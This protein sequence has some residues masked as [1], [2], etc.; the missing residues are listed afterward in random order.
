MSS[1]SQTRLLNGETHHHTGSNETL[2]VWDKQLQKVKENPDFHG[3]NLLADKQTK[4]T[5]W[6][7][8]LLRVFTPKNAPEVLKVAMV[9]IQQKRIDV[10]IHP[11][12]LQSL[13]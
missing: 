4:W 9:G 8:D 6:W 13:Y 10:C 5:S 2:K 1:E 12:A 7:Y 3:D 11:L